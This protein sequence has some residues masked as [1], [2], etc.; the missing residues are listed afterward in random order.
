M[1]D[2][3]L[4]FDGKGVDSILFGKKVD[5]FFVLDTSTKGIELELSPYKIDGRIE[6]RDT[7]QENSWIKNIY[8]RRVSG[9]IATLYFVINKSVLGELNKVFGKPTNIYPRMINP[10]GES[11]EQ[12]CQWL[13]S[14][15][16]IS[17]IP[18]MS[19]PE[20]YLIINN[21]PEATYFKNYEKFKER[22]K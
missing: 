11:R 10:S 21:N 19:K 4:N 1:A 14:D 12:S 20:I 13:F 7:T 17:Y 9:E 8:C 5:R 2:A 16:S 3:Q 22:Q 6:I 18:S 15:F